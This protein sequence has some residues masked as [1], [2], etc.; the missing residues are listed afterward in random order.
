LRSL[1][2]IA[3]IFAAC[4]GTHHGL[5]VDGT[6]LVLT[7]DRE[8]RGSDLIG[9][10]LELGSATVHLDD[11]T[12]D[13]DDAAIRL[14]RVT[15]VGAGELCIADPRGEHWAIPV[16]DEHGAVQLVCTSGAIGKC[17]RWGYPPARKALH[18]ACIRMVRADYGGDGAT[19]TRD[20]TMISFCDRAGVHRCPATAP[21][22][23]AI[24][25]PLGAVCVA[26]PRIEALATL[27][28]LAARY[29]RLVGHLGSACAMASAPAGGDVLFEWPAQP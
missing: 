25:A 1:A 2:V 14:Y 5:W 4:A 29:P 18:E 19:A 6:E 28:Q 17:I 9:A 24:W 27:K 21:A 12:R 7:T 13:P 3:A 26:R 15:V 10:T 16:V 23:E 22:L 11:V 20:G 8:F